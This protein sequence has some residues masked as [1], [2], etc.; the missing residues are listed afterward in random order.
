DLSR[1]FS[2]IILFWKSL[3][4]V[5][6]PL[7]IYFYRLPCCLRNDSINTGI[8]ILLFFTSGLIEIFFQNYPVLEIIKC[9][10]FPIINLLLPTTLL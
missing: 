5:G 9:G 8:Q 10:W 1:S 2:R 6:F 7:L 3:N 4:V